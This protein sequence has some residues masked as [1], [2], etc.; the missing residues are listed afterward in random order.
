MSVL[1]SLCCR[2][3]KEFWTFKFGSSVVKFSRPCC[4]MSDL[5]TPWHHLCHT[6]FRYFC[7]CLLHQGVEKKLLCYWFYFDRSSV[8]VCTCHL[9]AVSAWRPAVAIGNVHCVLSIISRVLKYCLH[10]VWNRSRFFLSLQTCLL[11][12]TLTY[13]CVCCNFEIIGVLGCNIL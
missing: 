1:L 13:I 7:S 10:G 12:V 9:P 5:T 11:R 8:A 2:L 3:G 6:A 4:D